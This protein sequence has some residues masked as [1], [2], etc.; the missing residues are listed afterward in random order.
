M[1][2]ADSAGNLYRMLPNAGQ[3]AEAREKAVRPEEPS[4]TKFTL[5]L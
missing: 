3:E 5:D 4:F 2:H 1:A